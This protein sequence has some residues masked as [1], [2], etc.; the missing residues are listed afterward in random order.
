MRI[1]S[2][3]GLLLAIGAAIY[4]SILHTHNRALFSERFHLGPETSIPLWGALLAVFLAGFLPTGITLVVDTLRR[5]L[6]LRRERRRQR[7]DEGLAATYRRGADLHADGQENRAAGELESF[8]AGRPDDYNGQLLYGEVL[9][10]VGRIDEAIEVH[11]RAGTAHP[12][13]VGVLYQLAA[14]HEK[15]GEAEIAREIEGRIVREFPGFGLEVLRKRRGAAIA[16]RDFAEAGKLHERVTEM[17][18]AGGDVTALARESNLAQGLTY[19]KG[20]LLLEQDRAAEAGQLFAE[21]LSHEPRFIPARIMLGEAELLAD[22]E[23]EAVAAW[24]KGYAE[25]GSPVFLQRIEDHFIEQEEPLAAIETLRALIAE[26]E[27]DLLPRFYLGRLYYRLEML[28]EAAKQLAAIEDRIRSSPT[29]H[30]LVGRI[31][32]RRGDLTRAVESY[33][34]CLRQLEVGRAEYLCRACHARHSD[35]SDSCPRCGAWNSIELDFEEERLSPE[36]LGVLEVPVW[37]V[38]EDSGELSLAAIAA[39]ANA[40]ESAPQSG[41]VAP[42]PPTHSSKPGK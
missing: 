7:E 17:I 32:H 1:R 10:E 37:G 41:A 14:D 23:T 15:R 5:D 30:F 36:D 6:A 12:H 31:H 28:D 42:V 4:A 33:G 39:V 22:R 19:Q 24:R 40:V 20:V 21:L 11:R 25:T 35:W 38:A 16:R 27:N 3:L 29:Y 34:A 2:F 18:S 26:A 8:L 13:S 9:R